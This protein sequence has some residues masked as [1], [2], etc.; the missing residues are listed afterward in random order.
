LRISPHNPTALLAAVA[1][2]IA[3]TIGALTGFFVGRGSVAQPSAAEVVADARKALAPVELG[4][5]QVPIEYRGAVR[6]GRGSYQPG[7][8]VAATEYEAAA[9]TLHR[10]EAAL[11][12][13]GEDMRAIDPAGYAA[14]TRSVERLV[15]AIDTVDPVA[16]VEAL[17]AR[18]NAAVESLA[19]GYE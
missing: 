13:V 18:S 2:V 3:L 6:G 4:L 17:A 11:A 9:A 10:A 5:E 15:A 14:A 12:G 7:R 1:L 19:G 8:I 16:R